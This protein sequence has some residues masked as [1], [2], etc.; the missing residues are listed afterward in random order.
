M[1]RWER[2]RH[3]VHAAVPLSCICRWVYCLLA[4][5]VVE[6]SLSRVNVA[7]GLSFCGNIVV[8]QYGR[9]KD[10][11]SFSFNRHLYFFM[12]TPTHS[13][14]YERAYVRACVRP[15]VFACVRACL[16]AYVRA[17]PH[18]SV[19]VCIRGGE[20]ET[21]TFS[22]ALFCSLL[23]TFATLDSVWLSNL[24]RR[25]VIIIGRKFKTKAWKGSLLMRNFFISSTSANFCLPLSIILSVSLSV[26]LSARLSVCLSV[27]LLDAHVFALVTGG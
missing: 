26:R 20:F 4:L 11:H 17:C 10:F 14:T 21:G 18:A 12:H 19:L 2:R 5:I 22:S 25:I 7:S 1:D 3:L 9:S 6:R 24:F 16:R 27:C 8:L 23:L 15:C 13:C